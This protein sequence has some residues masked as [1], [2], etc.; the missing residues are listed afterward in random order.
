MYLNDHQ[1]DYYGGRF[2]IKDLNE[3]TLL[4]IEPKKSRLV[5]YSS[6]S[7]NENQIEELKNGERYSL[8]VYFTLNK[9]AAA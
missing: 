8:N 1:I 6:G 7:E 4:S 3:T 2:S 5:V 9:N